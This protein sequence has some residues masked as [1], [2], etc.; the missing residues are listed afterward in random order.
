MSIY[1]DA[2]A[3]RF[4]KLMK[5]AWPKR[6]YPSPWT[7]RREVVQGIQDHYHEKIF[8]LQFVAEQ[9]LLTQEEYDELAAVAK[10]CAAEKLTEEMRNDRDRRLR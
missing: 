2:Y 9:G 3:E 7:N 1:I 4:D 6:R 5:T 8:L 10:D